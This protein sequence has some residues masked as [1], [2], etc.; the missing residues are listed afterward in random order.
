M[1][2]VRHRKWLNSVKTGYTSYIQW[3]VQFPSKEENG[4]NWAWA[5]LKIGDCNRSINLSLD[6]SDKYVKVSANK[7][8]ILIDELIEL[9]STLLAAS[10]EQFELKKA[11][12]AKKKEKMKDARKNGQ[13]VKKIS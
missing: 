2:E 9:K 6:T 10:A 13:K 1:K 5:E 7:L 12:E 4:D 11:H 8:Q 3:I